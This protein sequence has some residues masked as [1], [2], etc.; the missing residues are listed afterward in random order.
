MYLQWDMAI[1]CSLVAVG[2]LK[3]Y[4]SKVVQ[5]ILLFMTADVF[6]RSKTEHE[7]HSTLTKPMP[8][9]WSYKSFHEKE[10]CPKSL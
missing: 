7:F 8:L 10:F 3:L 6:K 9:H 4:G 1:A 5:K 2:G